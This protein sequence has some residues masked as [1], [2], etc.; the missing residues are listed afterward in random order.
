MYVCMCGWLGVFVGGCKDTQTCFEHHLLVRVHV[1]AYVC[2]RV[3]E[4]TSVGLS[5]G[6]GWV[7]M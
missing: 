2:V 4:R 5:A 1:Y 3:R 6:V 7:L